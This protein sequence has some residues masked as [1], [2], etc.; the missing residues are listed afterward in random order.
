MEYQVKLSTK[1][2]KAKLKKIKFE[3]IASKEPDSDLAEMLELSDQKFKT[4]M[5]N[6]TRTSMD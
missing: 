6:I 4:T 5:M 3:E 2:Q 1:N